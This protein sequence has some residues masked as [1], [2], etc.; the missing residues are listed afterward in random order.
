MFLALSLLSCMRKWAGERLGFERIVP[1]RQRAGRSISVSA[2]RVGPIEIWRSS[3]FLGAMIRALRCLPGGCG[4]FIPC[5]VGANHCRLRA[6]G[7]EQCGHGLNCKPLEVSGPL[8]LG[9]LVII[10]RYPAGSEDALIVGRLHMRYCNV[11]FAEKSHLGV[12]QGRKGC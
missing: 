7:W 9:S 1:F 10:F 4:R 2:V 8:V 3:R 5:R 12:A 6:V 11:S